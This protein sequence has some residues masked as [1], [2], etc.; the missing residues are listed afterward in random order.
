MSEVTAFKGRLIGEN[1]ETEITFRTKFA[2]SGALIFEIDDLFF[3]ND[4][5]FLLQDRFVK[6]TRLYE[7]RGVSEDGRQFR[8]TDFLASERSSIQSADLGSKVKL[9]GSCST[10]E[11]V[12]PVEEA[13]RTPVLSLFLK[14]FESFNA[15]SEQTPLGTIEMLGT[16]EPDDHDKFLGRI[17]VKA[18]TLGD[19]TAADWKEKAD[20]LADYVRRVMSFGFGINLRTPATQ[21]WY[22]QTMTIYYRSQTEQRKPT[23][24]LINPLH[25]DDIFKA[26]VTSFFLPPVEAKNLFFAIEW[27]AMEA[28]YNE[29]R[30]I[31]AMTALENLISSNLEDASFLP[32]NEFDKLRKRVRNTTREWL[33]ENGHTPE[34]RNTL[35]KKINEKFYDVNRQTLLD[36][37]Q[38]LIVKWR[39]PMDGIEDS[40]IQ[41]AKSARDKIV[42]RGHYYQEGGSDGVKLWDHYCVVREIVIRI[43]MTA[44]GFKGSYQSLLGGLHWEEFPPKPKSAKAASIDS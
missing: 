43:I 26:A 32:Q 1:G 40:D 25:L 21:V 42:H 11:I 39:V 36:K 2:K 38:I 34:E 29:V 33:E 19:M 28:T 12:I 24:P 4:V 23:M 35:V 14:G 30:L 6:E 9:S 27:F 37:L 44:I 8:T 13:Y 16:T 10:A 31:N 18:D 7:I 22:Q 17:L 41:A 20:A 3:T 15:L 5:L